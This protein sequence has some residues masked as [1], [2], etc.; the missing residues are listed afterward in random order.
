MAG[1]F[2]TER[3]YRIIL[4]LALA[5]ILVLAGD[6]PSRASRLAA[7]GGVQVVMSTGNLLI[8]DPALRMTVRLG[9]TP[10]HINVLGIGER[11]LIASQ[12]GLD[13]LVFYLDRPALTRLL[14]ARR[15]NGASG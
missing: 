14:P 7:T 11:T 2:M 13:G 6:L 10:L 12:S 9:G 8:T 3:L 1:M 5:L 15:F 4:L